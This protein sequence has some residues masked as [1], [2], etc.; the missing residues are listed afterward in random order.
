MRTITLFGSSRFSVSAGRWVP[1]APQTPGST[2][3]LVP[4]S[5]LCV[6]GSISQPWIV[7]IVAHMWGK[8]PHYQCTHAVQTCLVKGSVIVILT[9]IGI[10]RLIWK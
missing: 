4:S 9:E 7:N 3:A 5:T 2:G 8:N 6:R 1:G 10:V